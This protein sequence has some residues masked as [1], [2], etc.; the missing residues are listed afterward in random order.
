MALRAC[1]SRVHFSQKRRINQKAV[2]IGKTASLE[3]GRM[4]PANS[5]LGK[6]R[7]RPGSGPGHRKIIPSSRIR[8]RPNVVSREDWAGPGGDSPKS[9]AGITQ[10]KTHPPT[11]RKGIKTAR[12]A[13]GGNCQWRKAWQAKRLPRIIQA[14]WDI[15]T[16]L[17]IPKRIP[18]PMAPRLYV[19]PLK[20]PL[21]RTCTQIPRSPEF[22]FY[23]LL[24]VGR[25]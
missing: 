12:T 17:R 15:L 22:N 3:R 11:A 8:E 5:R 14:P 13:I 21:E 16:T 10:R 23:L 18:I 20:S 7:L 25:G 6:S 24:Q 19:A 9:R 1:P 2:T 4:T